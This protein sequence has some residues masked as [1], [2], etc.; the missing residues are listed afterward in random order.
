MRV[1][2][3]DQTD[4]GRLLSERDILGVPN[5]REGDETLDVPMVPLNVRNS[6]LHCGDRV[7]K[8]CA[9]PWVRDA[10]RSLRRDRD[11]CEIESPVLARAEDFVGS[12]VPLQLPVRRVHVGGDD[13]EGE[14]GEECGK[15]VVAVVE[16]VVA[17]GHGIETELVE[18][19][20]SGLT[21]VNGVEEGA[22]EFVSGIEEEGILLSGA[23][24]VDDRL[25]A[26]VASNTT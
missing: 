22:L 19:G 15:G 25:D 1:S 10:L 13:G 23:V 18:N 26:R 16:L 17:E 7:L 12:D 20:G 2:T 9:L 4:V 6:P 14:V 11:D 21:L 5:V 3:N 8:R 24:L